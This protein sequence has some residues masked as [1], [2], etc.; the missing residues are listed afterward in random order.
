MERERGQRL[1]VV[2]TDPLK[3]HYVWTRWRSGNTSEREWDLLRE[4][5]R[6]GFVAGRYALADLFLVADVDEVTLHERRERDATRTRGSVEQH[7][8][9]RDSLLRWY[10]AIDELEPG[11]VRFELPEAGLTPDLLA[12]TPRRVRSGAELFERLLTRLD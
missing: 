5:T 11:R 1:V 12:I 7:A 6:E 8:L 4:R 10:R 9:M 2:D 3:L